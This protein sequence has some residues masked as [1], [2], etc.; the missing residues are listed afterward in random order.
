M[1]WEHHFKIMRINFFLTI[2]LFY[3]GSMG[4][5]YSNSKTVFIDLDFILSESNSGKKIINDLNEMNKKNNDVIISTEKKFQQ[6]ENEIKS[7]K[8]IISAEEYK[9]RVDDYNFRINNF[10]LKKKEMLSKF[11]LEKKKKLDTF[12]SSLNLI[13]NDYMKKNS[14]DIIL[15]KKNIVL[16]NSNNEVSNDIL[17]LVNNKI[18]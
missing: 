14:I 8:N 9:N 5:S 17:L 6:E 11:E 7:Q 12:F 10:L 1:I 15:E 3:F 4:Q 2:F 18:N 16:A 13:L